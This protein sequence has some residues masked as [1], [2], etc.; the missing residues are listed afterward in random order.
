M[1]DRS[2][3]MWLNIGRTATRRYKMSTS[4]CSRLLGIDRELPGLI[5]EAADYFFC[6]VTPDNVPLVRARSTTGNLYSLNLDGR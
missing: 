6:G 1:Q 3:N 2:V 4:L 5:D